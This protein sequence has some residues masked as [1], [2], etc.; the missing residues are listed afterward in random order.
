MSFNFYLNHDSF[1]HRINPTIKYLALIIWFLTIP[2]LSIKQNIVQIIILQVLILLGKIPYLY[3]QKKFKYIPIIMIVFY[4]FLS[5]YPLLP[6]EFTYSLG[7]RLYVMFAAVLIVNSTTALIELVTIFKFLSKKI[8]RK[9]EIQDIVMIFVLVINFIPLIGNEI[10][11][12]NQSLNS[13]NITIK[14]SR[15]NFLKIALRALVLRLDNLV[16]ELEL[17]FYARNISV[18]NVD[19]LNY[20]RKLIKD[21][22][23]FI[24]L[25]IIIIVGLVMV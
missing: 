18:A 11:K 17:V 3:F 1:L 21:D 22:Y 20:K 23:I 9:K 19:N 7:I 5:V 13:R 12:I 2:F 25:C 24:V 14:E 16:D 10:L 4:V 8:F 6:P 15:I